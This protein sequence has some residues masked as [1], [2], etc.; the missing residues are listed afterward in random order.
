MK[1]SI[2]VYCCRMFWNVNLLLSS[3]PVPH[4]ALLVLVPF[5]GATHTYIIT[6]G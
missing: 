1:V 2:F 6:Y 4:V 3:V 5:V